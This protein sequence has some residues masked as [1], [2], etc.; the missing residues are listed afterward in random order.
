MDL[1]NVSIKELVEEL[2]SR[3]AV[4]KIVVEPYEPYSI[5]VGDQTISDG[6]PIVILRIWD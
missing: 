6:G 1:K 5:T 2:V 4:E 3:E